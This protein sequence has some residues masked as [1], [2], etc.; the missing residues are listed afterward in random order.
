M[1]KTHRH[2]KR[3]IGTLPDRKRRTDR[4]K[5][6]DTQTDTQKDTQTDGQKDMQT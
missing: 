4:W 3:H 2:T 1:K 6:I 5:K